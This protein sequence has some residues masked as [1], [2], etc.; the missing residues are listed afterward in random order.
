MWS[1]IFLAF[2]QGITEFFPV[3]SSGHLSLLEKFFHFNKQEALGLG[4]ILHLGT[5]CSV[6]V[7][8][9]KIFCFFLQNIKKNLFFLYYI[10]LASVPTAIIG[11]FLK[12]TVQHMVFNLDVIALFFGVTAIILLVSHFFYKKNSQ[13]FSES[14]FQRDINPDLLF[15]NLTSL[16]FKKVFCIG[17]VQGLAVFPGLSR[18]GLTI[19]AGQLLGLS[20]LGS[21][22]FSFVLML[23]VVIG[24]SLLEFSSVG[25]VSLPFLKVFFAFLVSFATGLIV[26]K[27]LQ[28]I[29]AQDK[30]YYFAYYLF[31]LGIGIYLI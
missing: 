21:G 28:Y 13:Y 20:P 4:L 24:A 23:P 27:L 18:S 6:L 9:R 3:S 2:V 12:S 16:N 10:L 14:T 8:Y 29:L 17:C 19:A 7:F 1:I 5:V 15:S 11:L 26:L 25:F 30:F 31:L 22:F